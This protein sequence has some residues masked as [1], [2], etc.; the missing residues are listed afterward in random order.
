[1]NNR[2]DDHRAAI[3]SLDGA[4]SR[5][6]VSMDLTM[7]GLLVDKAEEMA[8][9]Y[10]TH[11]DWTTVEDRWFDERRDGRS[12]RGS[13]RKVY[14]VLSSRFKTA[15]RKLPAI[16]QL[17]SVFKQCETTRDKAQVLY[18]YLVEEDPLVQYAIHTYINRLLEDGIEALQFD[19]ESIEAILNGF[20]YAD[21]GEFDYAAS[22]TVRWGEGFR[23]VLREIGV[24]ESQQALGGQVPTIGTI[25]LLVASGYSWEQDGE[26]WLTQPL[27]WLYLF[28]QHPYWES[29]AER[30]S[31]H[32]SWDASG[33][34][35]EIKLQPVGDTYGWADVSEVEK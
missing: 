19:Q 5:D 7:C 26:E 29:L 20:S 8:R 1:M 12:T 32:P 15:D 13:S 9:L 18:F 33:L 31:Q 14:R 6:T 11:R 17:P 30:L 10:A 35:G 27:G 4:F 2:R 28:Q 16:T 34:H 3:P 22:T 23:G 25:P 24:I 21:G